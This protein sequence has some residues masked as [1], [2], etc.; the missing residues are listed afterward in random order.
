MNLRGF[1]GIADSG[2]GD[3]EAQVRLLIDARACAIQLRCKEW[4]ASDVEEIAKA[5]FP[6]CDQAGIPLILNDLFLPDCSH[7]SHLGQEDGPLRRTDC[8]KGFLIGRSTHSLIQLSDAIEEGVDYAGFG[9]VFSTTTKKTAGPA[10]G[11]DTLKKAAQLDLPLVAIGG[12]TLSSLPLVHR[13][14]VSM[15]TAISSIWSAPDPS[16]VLRKFT[17]LSD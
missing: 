5:V 4:S 11:L 6:L 7:G 16:A 8:P 10:L 17:K 1:Y 15:W 2:F 13:S 9:P 12:I 14:G 3:P